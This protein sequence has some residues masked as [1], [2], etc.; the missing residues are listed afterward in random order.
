M[1]ISV[2]SHLSTMS[3]HHE[4]GPL[5]LE[6]NR[7]CQAYAYTHQ[8]RKEETIKVYAIPN[9]RTDQRITN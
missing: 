6:E 9:C 1:Y 5:F 7:Y 4:V 2:L 8:Q 3:F